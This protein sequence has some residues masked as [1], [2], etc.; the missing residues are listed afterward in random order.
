ML[1]I[2]LKKIFEARK[3]VRVCM[4]NLEGHVSERMGYEWKYRMKRVEN[5]V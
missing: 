1:K 2:I 4:M 3:I 5:T